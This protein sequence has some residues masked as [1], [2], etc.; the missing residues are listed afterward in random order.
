MESE[1]KSGRL[2]ERLKLSL[3]VR[4]QCRESADYEWVEMTRLLDVTPFGASFTLS[5]SVEPGRLLHLTLPMPRQLRCFDHVEAQYRVWALVRHIKRIPPTNNSPLRVET[6]VAFVGKRAPA[7]Y[8]KNPATIYEVAASATESGLWSFREK[9]EH[10]GTETESTRGRR[11]EAET[12]HAI[13]LEVTIEVLDEEG[14][15]KAIERTVTENLSRRG[16]AV[17]TTL[18]VA[19]GQFVRLTSPQYQISVTAAVR[20]HRK[21]PDGMMRLHL[22]F[23]DR[24]WPLEGVE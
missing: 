8:E 9:P 16:A 21:A 4:V 14:N 13:P 11:T 18:N 19:R 22:E 24:Q 12:R 3:P 7:S 15:V 10:A 2:R 23:V 1:K 20:A 17:F 5:R 6:G